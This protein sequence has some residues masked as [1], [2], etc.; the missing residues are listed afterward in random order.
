MIAFRW[1][2]FAA[3]LALVLITVASAIRAVVLP[4]GVPVRI[5]RVVMRAL[6]GLFHLRIRSSASYERRDAVMAL[7]GPVSLLALLGAWL[8]L[9]GTGYAAMFWGIGHYSIR[10]AIVLSG[11]SLFTLGLAGGRGLPQVGLVFTEAGL[12]LLLLALLI[13]YLPSI[14]ASFSRREV[15]VTLNEVRAGSPPSG[16]EMIER[17]VRIQGLERLNQ[18]WE[19]WE[20]WFVEIE[21]SHTS[22]PAL[23]FFRSPQPDHSWVIAAGAVLDAAA[24]VSSTLDVGEPVAQANLCIRAGFLSLRRQAAFFGLPVDHDPRPDDPI[25]V[26][27]EEFAS[28]YERIV[29][30]EAKV[31]GGVEECWKRWAGWRVNYDRV[32]VQLAHL[33]DAPPAPW[34]SDRPL[35]GGKRH[36]LRIATRRRSVEAVSREV[37]ED[38]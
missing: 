9:V 12:G 26:S 3:G 7:F 21:E 6:R 35:P 33:T 31:R 14:Y 10:T 2:G 38:R 37:P 11:S 17:Y 20:E 13:T 5:T 22:F 23:A 34:S 27:F 25:S 28:A 19:L 8:V 30:T 32:L 15:M 16:V 24:F 1:L 36:K 4:R 29:A 18:Q